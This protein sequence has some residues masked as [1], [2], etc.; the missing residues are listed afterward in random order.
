[1]GSLR[2]TNGK[3]EA[4]MNN[5][6]VLVAMS[7]GV[8]SA[9]CA[10]L[11][12]EQ[13]FDTEGI[14]MVLW[15]DTEK[16]TDQ[17]NPLPDQNCTD[18]KKVAE[19]L[20]IPHSCVALGDTFRQNIVDKF[21][22]D[23][24]NG[25]T[26]NPCVECNK[27]IKFGSLMKIADEAGFDYLATGHYARIEQSESGEYLLKKAK[28]LSKDQSYF[29][30]A[31]KKE[32]LSRIIFPLGNYSKPEIR[33]IAQ[34]NGLKSAQRAD[35]QDICFIPN[36]EYSDFIKGYCKKEYPCGNFISTDGTILGKHSGIINYTVG[37]R[38]GLGIALGKPMFVCQKNISEN[39]V[40]LCDNDSLF[41]ESLT[42]H[43]VNIL[44]NYIPKNIVR[45]EAKVRYRHT[46]TAATV[47]FLED[48]RARVTFDVPQRAI[49]PGQS[50]VFYDGDTLIGGG[51]I[52]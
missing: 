20:N 3:S 21:I 52:E 51:I 11:V 4:S 42:A 35:S 30:W 48:S 26:P 27:C 33:E 1:M 28:D 2:N 5:K 6:K 14:T 37:Q 23:Y 38:K 24:E 22:F 47:E 8:D 32:Y 49:T 39:T 31:I 18:A 46:P 41:S 45:C 7:G 34:I 13:G 25:L 50:V 10:Y 16:I 17:Q 15:S 44:V 12:K 43:S 19:Q 29:L 9:V 36:G 40:T